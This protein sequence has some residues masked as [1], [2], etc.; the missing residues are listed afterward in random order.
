MKPQ[1]L[2]L[3]GYYPRKRPESLT[4][5]RPGGRLFRIFDRNVRKKI[6]VQIV[7]EKHPV[8]GTGQGAE[9]QKVQPGDLQP[10]RNDTVATCGQ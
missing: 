10:E 7:F 2:T 1:F 6:A 3:A 8:G 9:K 5:L 4:P